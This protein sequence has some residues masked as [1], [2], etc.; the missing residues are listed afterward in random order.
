MLN[1]CPK[2]R[3][4]GAI[5]PLWSDDEM[6]DEI[7]KIT[8]AYAYEVKFSNCRTWIRA[9]Q[10]MRCSWNTDHDLIYKYIGADI[11]DQCS[12]AFCGME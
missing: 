3:S 12:S 2:Y 6:P 1:S 8:V 11:N 4:C 10:V 9:M 7:G 5:Y